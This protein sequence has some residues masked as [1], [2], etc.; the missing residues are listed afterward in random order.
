MITFT[1]SD[2]SL[3]N[4]VLLSVVKM[5]DSDEGF[6][7]LLKGC[8]DTNVLEELR[9]RKAR[10]LVEVSSRLRT[11]A[12]SFSADEF[13]HE[14]RKVD[15]QRRDQAMYEYFVRHGASRTMICDLWKKTSDE[16]AA[17]RRALLPEG[18]LGPG[19]RAMPK[20]HA[21]REAIH[22][23]W[24]E[25]EKTLPQESHRQRLYQLH[26]R[27]PDYSI[28]TLVSTL[29]EFEQPE[30]KRAKR[31]SSDAPADRV[32]LAPAFPHARPQP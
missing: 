1:L 14:L 18:A 8:C 26:Q 4:A 3:I 15:L 12:I 17:M 20:V 7:A 11:L 28:D 16:V 23:A 22:E 19:R 24:A 10:D 29:N 25:I 6:R 32:R 5:I 2:A 13:L 27:F 21:V 31:P 9:H 30:R